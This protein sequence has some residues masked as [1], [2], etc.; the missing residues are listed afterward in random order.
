MFAEYCVVDPVRGGMHGRL[1]GANSG[2]FSRDGRYLATWF[3]PRNGDN[4]KDTAPL[5]LWELPGE[6]N[7]TWPLAAASAAAALV[8]AWALLRNGRRQLIF[9]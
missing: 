9:A 5:Q 2:F 6:R 7:W 4:I 8:G 1:P 3:W